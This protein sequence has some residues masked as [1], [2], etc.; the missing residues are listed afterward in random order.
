M[1]RII[2]FANSKGGVGKTTTVVNVGAGLSR[3]EKRVLL[4]DMDPQASLTYSLGFAA[5]QLDKTVYHALH[6]PEIAR[7][8]LL[9][10]RENLLLVPAN[11][12]LSAA[13]REF[14]AETERELLLRE[15]LAELEEFDYILIDCPPSMG[16]LTLNALAAAG[17]VIIPLQAEYLSL[18]GVDQ[19]EQVIAAV[20]Q[21]LNPALVIS[22]V[23]LTRFDRRKLLHREV[24]DAVAKHFG[25]R[26]LTPQ[27]RDSVVLAEAPSFGKDVFSY[28][29]KSS[30]AMDYL[31]LCLRISGQGEQYERAKVKA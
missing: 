27:V 17:E 10:V 1:S 14:A 4:V 23:V 19:L 22:G 20:R 24:L 6:G 15:R 29:P 16:L 25:D 2:A 7:S 3:L 9:E 26:L 30:G 18:Q 13:E 28:R 11:L 12:E 21:R 31:G 8:S 5:H